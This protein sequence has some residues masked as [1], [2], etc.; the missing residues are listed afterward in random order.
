MA[1]VVGEPDKVVAFMYLL[2]KNV[3]IIEV[4]RM[5][6]S[7]EIIGTAKDNVTLSNDAVVAEARRLLGRVGVEVG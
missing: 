6:M 5:V 2:L 3:P 1:T 7:A 4:E